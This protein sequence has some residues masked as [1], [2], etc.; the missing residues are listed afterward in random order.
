MPCEN[1][2]GVGDPFGFILS[3][4]HDLVLAERE[5]TP[6]GRPV[7]DMLGFGPLDQRNRLEPAAVRSRRLETAGAK[8]LD[9]VAGGE[10]LAF[11]AGHP[12]L[13]LIAG[14][15]PDVSHQVVGVDPLSGLGSERGG[16]EKEER[17]G[18]ADRVQEHKAA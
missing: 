8:L 17:R 13:I 5:G 1:D 12:P 15:D 6:I 9:D 14:E 3:E 10:R 7:D 2:G 11:S 16:E 4:Q 18:G